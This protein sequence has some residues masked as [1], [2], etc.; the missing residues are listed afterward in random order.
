M[1]DGADDPVDVAERP[2]RLDVSRRQE[3]DVDP[4]R[5][6]HPGIVAVLVHPV[7]GAGQADVR[8]PPEAD[9]LA[10]LRL[11]RRI[12]ADRIFVQLADRVAQIEQRQQAGGVPSG[13]GGELVALQQHDVAPAEPGQ[14]VERADADHAATN[15]DNPRVGL[16]RPSPDR[17]GPWGHLDDGL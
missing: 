2:D 9:A 14:V 10:G 17:N 7:G 15:D 4:D 12:E 5:A 8:D 1:L 11:Q 13:A 3:A 16:H 6:R